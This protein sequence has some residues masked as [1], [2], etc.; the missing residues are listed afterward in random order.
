MAQHQHRDRHT[1]HPA[2]LPRRVVDGAAHGI[3]LRGELADGRARQGR[4]HHAD[5]DPAEQQAR[6]PLR[7]IRGLLA[8]H[9]QEP[10]SAGRVDQGA[11]HQERT[12]A[13][14][15]GQAPGQDRRRHDQQRPRRHG[16][17]G[18]RQAVMPH[19][20]HVEKERE[21]H[22]RERNAEAQ[23]GQVHIAIGAMLEQ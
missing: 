7:Q 15:R 4:Q 23:R 8:R 14:P 17:A 1:H 11:A 3:V 10:Q 22:H 9:Q 5:A 2:D 21:E 12:V 19:P 6:Q 16:Q 18:A 20:R 13:H